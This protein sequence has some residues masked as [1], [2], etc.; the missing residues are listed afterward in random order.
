MGDLVGTPFVLFLGLPEEVGFEFHSEYQPHAHWFPLGY[1]FQCVSVVNDSGV[2]NDTDTAEPFV[3][4]AE[5]P[6]LP[7]V[8]HYYTADDM[9]EW[10]ARAVRVTPLWTTAE[11]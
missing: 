10:L 8:G 9:K 6:F 4:G 2:V 3:S 11:R 5:N 1:P 7:Q